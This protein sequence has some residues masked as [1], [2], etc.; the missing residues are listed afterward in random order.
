MPK[1]NKEKYAAYHEAGHCIAY[2]IV[3]KIEFESVDI[4]PETDKTGKNISG[5]IIKPEPISSN[6][7]N[8]AIL[9]YAGYISEA[10]YRNIPLCIYEFIYRANMTEEYKHA[11]EF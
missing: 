9:E 3:M 1:C 2:L 8:I 11:D 10:K 7:P 5:K 4:I 6:I